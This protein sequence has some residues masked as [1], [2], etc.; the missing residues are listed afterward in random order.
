MASTPDSDTPATPGEPVLNTDLLIVGGGMVG[1]TL[2]LAV[3]EAGIR[4]VVVDAGD[5]VRTVAPEFD[6]RAMAIAYAPY[7]MFRSIG[8]WP[9]LAPYAQAINEIRVSDGQVNV[10][11]GTGK[12]PSPLFLHF[13]HQA[14]GD[15]PFGYMVENR[16]ILAGLWAAAQERP[17]ITLCAPA[18]LHVLE[19][20]PACVSATIRCAPGPSEAPADLPVRARLVIGADGRGSKVR[21]S[22][23]ITC[24]S[25]GYGQTAIVATVI[26]AQDHGGI[27]EEYF[28]PAGPFAILPLS[29]LPDGRHRSSLVWT[30]TEA[31]AAAL[32]SLEDAA[33][34]S[35][36]RSR[37][38]DHLGQVATDGPR[39]SYPLGYQH[40]D[41]YVDQR[42]ALAGD[43]A[44]GI[45]P[46]AGQGL[47]LGLRDVA[48]LAEVLADGY[49]VG[50]DLGSSALLDRYQRW[51]R[52]DGLILLAVTDG[53]NRLFSNDIVPV[54]W[55]R[56]LGL[57]AVDKAP[58]LKRFFMRHARGT[59]GKLPR[60]LSGDPL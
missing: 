39:W 55:A 52:A 17:E 3:S 37:F 18:E 46:I 49:R 41:R 9:H 40:A 4:S 35:H 19:R 43:S 8:I 21:K 26:H 25:G 28:L 44:H 45:H 58:G 27:A 33:F 23:G 16:H 60:L 57:A 1:L 24:F 32:L 29:D 54:R 11:P 5:P 12:G 15:E 30:E 34:D 14:L 31:A 42:L 6:G 48:A 50:T 22:A 53:L 10:K 13:E 2:A 7:Q 59:V 51:R 47:N 20:T 36:L 56:D 38:G